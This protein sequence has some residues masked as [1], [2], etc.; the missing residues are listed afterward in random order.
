VID[1]DTVNPMP[2]VDGVALLDEVHAAFGRYVV[3]PSAEAHDATTLWC[4]ATHGQ[5]AWEHAPRLAPISPEKRC[6]KS[7]LMDIAEAVCYRPLITINASTAAVARS[8]TP[9]D[10]PTLM[11][12][13]A[14]TIF[15]TKRAAENHE[16]VRGILNA[17]HQRNRP[18]VRWDIMT[19]SR[20]ECPTFAMAMLAAIG[21][22]P[23]TI[24]DRAIVIRMR[25]RAPGEKV[26]PFRTR[27]DAPA[28]H[29]LR[30]RLHDWI[31]PHLDTLSKA[32]P[33]LPVEDRAADTWEPLVIVADL[34]G[35]DWP[36]RARRACLA[37]TGDEPDEGVGIQLLAD[38]FEIWETDR[39]PGRGI[40]EDHLFTS[41][42][43]TRL[44]KVEE[45]PWSEWGRKNEPLTARGLAAL[46]KPY[47]V[48]SR[49]VRI[50]EVTSKGYARAD[51]TDS[52]AR[53]AATRTQ[54]DT[55]VTASHDDDF[56]DLT[57]E[58]GC[59]EGVS[60]SDSENVTW[61]EQREQGICDAVTDVTDNV[62][63][64]LWETRVFCRFCGD[65]IPDAMPL[66]QANGYCN[67]GRCIAAAHTARRQP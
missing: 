15:S 7:R 10:P 62:R 18:Y 9:D 48:R 24:M 45:S 8:I 16:D 20:E 66:A 12:D 49:T 31:W 41:T 54:S 58:D 56:P 52:W 53:Y 17:G 26:T 23:D 40:Y 19:R 44:H 32:E 39:D 55:S 27:R 22:L 35:G 34:A 28:L 1:A 3:F 2:P 51:L 67:K 38:L 21:G 5:P 37:M 60:D 30:N 59:N 46:L 61:S 33:K 64:P 47:G 65:E 4:A 14:D 11:V 25:R 6:G 57:S 29:A 63:E 13:E 36:D 42:I 43:L 50:G